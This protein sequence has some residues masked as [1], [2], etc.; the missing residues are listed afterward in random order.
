MPLRERIQISF[1]LARK[2]RNL[3]DLATTEDRNKDALETLK[4]H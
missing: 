2:I 3:M 1:R 4:K